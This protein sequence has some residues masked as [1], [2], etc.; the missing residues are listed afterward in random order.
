MATQAEMQAAVLKA[1]YNGPLTDAAVSAAYDRAGKGIAADANGNPITS[2]TP[3]TPSTP[4]N[5]NGPVGTNPAVN[6]AILTN[7]QAKANQEYLNAKLALDTDQEAYQKAAQAVANDL[8]VAGVTGTY[9][10][11]PTQAAIKQLADVAQQ[12]AATMLNYATQFGTWGVP[13]QGQQT[14]AAQKQGFDEANTAAQLTGWYTPYSYTPPT[15]GSMTGAPSAAGGNPMLQQYPPGTVVRTAGNQFGVVGANG[16]LTPGDASNPA[17]YQAIQSGSG[18]M[19]VPDA[20]FQPIAAAP[21]A[22]GGA[23]APDASGQ[24][25]GAPPGYQNG[26]P[27]Q[28]LAGNQQ[29]FSQQ[30]DAQKQALA[31]WQAQQTAAQNYL[32]MMT[33]L[34]GPA[35]YA[36]YQQVLGSTPGGM[37]DLVAAAAGQYIPGGGATTGVAPTPVTLQNFVGSTTGTPDPSNQAAMNS[38]VAPNQ[39]APQTWN[40]LTP[41]Q[42]QMLLGTWESQGYTKDDA[43]A[44]FNQSLPKYA[45][46]V[47]SSGQFKLQ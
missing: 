1:G 35:D 11:M 31:Q 41:S 38:L 4:A 40:A 9:N 7:L 18:I 16:S 25:P 45:A 46:S 44:L 42:Q 6:Q 17:I 3:S 21:T 26:Q 14:Q 28:T 15:G 37:K 24:A 10:G 8:S 33:N 34:R 23:A 12:Q 19:T 13:Q 20:A 22:T 29:A 39:M 36:K 2:S 27:I 30:M 5:P 32:T 43:Q 47:P